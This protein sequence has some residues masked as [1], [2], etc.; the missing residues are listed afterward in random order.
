MTNFTEQTIS[1]YHIE[2]EI[3]RGGIE[4]ERNDESREWLSWSGFR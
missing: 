2:E 4:V 1:Q 3:G